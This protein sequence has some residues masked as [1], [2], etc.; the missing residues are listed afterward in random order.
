[1][2][3]FTIN[4][5]LLSKNRR[6]NKL[7]HN[8]THLFMELTITVRK[9]K[10]WKRNCIENSISKGT[11]HSKQQLVGGDGKFIISAYATR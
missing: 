7:L 11:I 3:S 5:T 4:Y 6:I 9:R 10:Q 8:V 1:M 2:K